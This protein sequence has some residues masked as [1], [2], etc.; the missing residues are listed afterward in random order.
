MKAREKWDLLVLNSKDFVNFIMSNLRN[1]EK[2]YALKNSHFQCR[3]KT[4]IFF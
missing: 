1:F 3:I 2:L 4:R